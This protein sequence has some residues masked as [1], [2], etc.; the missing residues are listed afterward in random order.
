MFNDLL[1]TQ[2]QDN[3]AGTVGQI[4]AIA[5]EDIDTLPALAAA[6]SLVTAATDI[7]PKVGKQ[8]ARIYIT[9]ET[10]KVET[11]SV[12]ERDGKGRETMLSGRYPAMGIE[13]ENAI[14][15]FQNTPS[16]LAYK[17]AR[18]GKIYLL[19]VTQLLISSTE[20]SLDIPAYFETGDA[21]SGEKRPDQNGV[22]L[23]WK[24]TA[25]HGPIEYAGDIQLTPTPE[26]G[27]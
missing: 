24:F 18:N 17:L 23:T 13:L 12:G 1:F 11:K 9:D 3:L 20:L 19:G 26:P 16:V 25:A 21:S 5:N 10:G 2:G 6:T 4:Y 14:R 22:L 15:K 7:L 8:W 27:P